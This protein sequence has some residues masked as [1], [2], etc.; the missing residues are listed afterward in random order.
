MPDLKT[1]VEQ[2]N[3]Q[4]LDT[5]LS[6]RPVL[7]D[8]QPAI[9]A[10]PGM[11]RN[12]ILHSAPP[13]EWRRM[14]GPHR[15]GI[16]G[17][18]VWE[19]LA[20]T[21][22][23]AQAMIERGEILIEPCHHHDTVG[24]GTGITSASTPMLVV[25]N[26]EHGNRAYSC[27]S[28]GGALQLLKWGSYD[29]RIAAN[30]SWQ[31][32]VLG[33]ALGAAVRAT[34]GVDAW[35]IVKQAVQMGD[36][37]HNRSIAASSLFFREIAVALLDTASDDDTLTACVRFLSEAE[38]FF[39]HGIMAAAKAMLNAAAGIQY[40]TMVTA[41][42]RNGVEFGIRVSG[43]GETWFTAPANLVRGLYF[44]SEWGPD[45]AAPDLGDSCIAETAGLGGFIQAAAPSVQSYVGGSMQ[46]AIDTTRE[47]ETICIGTNPDIR[48]PSLNFDAAPIGI[49]I[50]KVVRTGTAPL[51]D[52]AITHREQGLIGAGEVRA[53]MACFEK[54]LRAFASRHGAS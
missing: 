47:M 18:I 45:D 46:R 41:M 29:E 20:K 34:G 23:D 48:I 37:C 33:P 35:N 8:V 26:L 54:A 38:H 4:A 12:M 25:E 7:V 32:E 11:C 27:L 14:C 36:E 5:V 28:E 10:V 52:T 6:A 17:A 31:A 43:C 9:D 24:A 49:D 22:A 39:L 13:I 42:A 44:R 53:P 50:R 3:R 1:K 19:G 15:N 30:L 2:A 40:S 16:L 21:P 51:I